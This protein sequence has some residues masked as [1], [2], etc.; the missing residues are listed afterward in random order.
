[1]TEIEEQM[2][3][4][5]QQAKSASEVLRSSTAE[6]KSMGLLKAADYILAHKDKIIAANS[7]DME[8]A[9]G[10]NLNKAWLDRL[11][12]DDTR[13][14]NMVDSL[15]MIAELPDPVGR[16]LR[17]DTR[18]NGLRI[19]RISTPIGVIGVIFE[20]RPNVTIDAAALSVKA[21]NTAILRCGSESF[22]TSRA[23]NRCFCAGLK[24]AGISEK[25]V[26]LIPTRDRRAVNAMLKMSNFIDVIIPRG[27][28]GLV[29]LIQ[30]EARVPVFSHLEGIVHIYLHHDADPNVAR[31]VIINSKTRR[32]GICGAVECLLVDERFLSKNGNQ[33]FDDLISE[34]VEL[35]VG[36]G[37][38]QLAGV[39][40]AKANDWGTEFLDMILAV[41]VVSHLDDA[42]QHI[43][44]FGSNHTDCIITTNDDVANKFF[45]ALDS[46]ILMKNASTQFADGGEFGFGAEIGIATGK[47]HA[48][49][50][51][52][53]EQL[54]TFKYIVEG[55]G[56]IRA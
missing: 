16:I 43:R 3:R 35:R 9:K 2:N 11:F 5:G 56:T 39:N 22:N 12:L 15:K 31:K 55:Q 18:P 37:L 4:I 10:K 24:N 1:M 33:L 47:L 30:K 46:A 27:G 44:K 17:E 48:R 40:L 54:T 29:E 38:E 32:P 23:L 20:S 42:V 28:R 36:K 13:L 52:G 21:G 14:K 50:P 41:R 19:K 45:S 53:L 49:G 25:C 51:V 26:Q 7:T 34:G 8:L 6:I